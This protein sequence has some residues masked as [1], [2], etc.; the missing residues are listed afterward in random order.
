MTALEQKFME[1]VPG[2]LRRIAEALER[3]SEQLKEQNDISKEQP[4]KSS[5]TD[6]EPIDYGM[7]EMEL[8]RMRIKGRI[9]RTVTDVLFSGTQYVGVKCAQE[10][11]KLYGGVSTAA[12]RNAIFAGAINGYIPEMKDMEYVNPKTKQKAIMRVTEGRYDIE[13]KSLVTWLEQNGRRTYGSCSTISK[14]IDR[15]LNS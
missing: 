3:I 14:C 2:T 4:A 1:V 6:N 12:I 7:L 11:A 10:F 13:L 8:T 15:I 5:P 9:L